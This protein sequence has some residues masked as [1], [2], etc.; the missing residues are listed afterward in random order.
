MLFNSNYFWFLPTISYFD[1][2]YQKE[3][4]FSWLAWKATFSWGYDEY[5]YWLYLCELYTGKE[6]KK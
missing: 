1:R 4:S 2:Y 3:I 6:D 5:K